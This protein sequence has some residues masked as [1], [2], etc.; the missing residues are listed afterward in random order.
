MFRKRSIIFFLTGLFFQQKTQK[1]IYFSE[2]KTSTKQ[3]KD[4]KQKKQTEDKEKDNGRYCSASPVSPEPL[5]KPSLRYFF[6]GLKI[7]KLDS[8][9]NTIKQGGV[10]SPFCQPQKSFEEVRC[11]FPPLFLNL[12]IQSQDDI[13]VESSQAETHH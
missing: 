8:P 13:F 7:V 5:P 1:I 11:C 4:F 2:N 3:Q 10:L 6:L 12:S 9:S